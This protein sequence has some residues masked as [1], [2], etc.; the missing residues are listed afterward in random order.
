MPS[1]EMLWQ[2]MREC[3]SW[4]QPRAVHV[5]CGWER[6][7]CT[8]STSVD[9]VEDLL[10]RKCCSAQSVCIHSSSIRLQNSSILNACW[11]SPCACLLIKSAFD[12]DTECEAWQAYRRTRW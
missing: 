11:R 6:P 2:P 9:F 8:W 5:H 1:V 10:Y 12:C 3:L 4:P 7:N